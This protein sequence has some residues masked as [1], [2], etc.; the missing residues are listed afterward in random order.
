MPQ[1]Q[2]TTTEHRR[3]STR[4][5]GFDYTSHGAYFVTI[6]T[7]DR[8]NL[9]GRIIDGE[10]K[11][12]AAGHIVSEEWL[13]S[14]ELRSNVEIDESVVMPNHFHMASYFCARTTRARCGVPLH[15]RSVAASLDRCRPSYATSR[16]R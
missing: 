12:N 15:G 14:G 1:I 16:A 7:H 5:R 4:P 6:V 2:H 11:L 8:L 9:F 3:R 10:M 13:R